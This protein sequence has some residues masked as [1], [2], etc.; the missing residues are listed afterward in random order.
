MTNSI[1][2]RTVECDLSGDPETVTVSIPIDTLA[3]IT[4]VLGSRRAPENEPRED[5]GACTDFWS[6]AT[7]QIF[8][9]WWEEGLESYF[10]T[11]R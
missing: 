9:R 2:V 3:R 1:V 4:R 6:A 11:Q 5:M 7:S 8:L 10:A